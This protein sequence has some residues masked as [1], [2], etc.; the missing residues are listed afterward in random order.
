MEEVLQSKKDIASFTLD[1][2]KDEMKEIGEK[3]FRAGQIYEWI[4]RKLADG[5]DGNF[6]LRFGGGLIAVAHG[7]SGIA[8]VGHDDRAVE[9]LFLRHRDS[10]IFAASAVFYQMD[11]E[12]VH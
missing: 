11:S 12:S 6:L 10:P 3:P 4:H 9:F 7:A 8:A 1:E 2:L 5:F